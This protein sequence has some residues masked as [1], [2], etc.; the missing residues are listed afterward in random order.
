M[1][2]G[3]TG[4]ATRERAKAERDD[5]AGEDRS[6]PQNSVTCDGKCPRDAEFC[7][8]NEN[9][10]R[11]MWAFRERMVLGGEAR[12]HIPQD[13]PDLS[14]FDHRSFHPFVFCFSRFLGGKLQFLYSIEFYLKKVKMSAPYAAEIKGFFN[15]RPLIVRASLM[16]CIVLNEDEPVLLPPLDTLRTVLDIW[17][18]DDKTLLLQTFSNVPPSWTPS[19][20]LKDFEGVTLDSDGFVTKV[21]LRGKRLTGT[22]DLTKLPQG[23]EELYLYNNQLTGPIDLTKLPQGLEVLVLSYTRLTGTIDLTKLPQGLKE[24]DL[25][26]NRFTPV[27]TRPPGFVGAFFA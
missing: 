7:V 5:A 23:L 17:I 24:L 27:P 15:E 12:T 22:I 21:D 20:E 10:K 2:N 6:V 19:T 25:S 26:Y 14:R 3:W 18:T 8:V 4:K 16:L 13:V 11:M 9:Q 1:E